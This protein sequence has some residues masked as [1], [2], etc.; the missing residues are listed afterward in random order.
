MSATVP[1]ADGSRDEDLPLKTAVLAKDLE[2]AVAPIA[3]ID[4]A[5]AI[6]SE[7]VH[8]IAK[9]PWSRSGGIGLRGRGGI[10]RL[11]AICAPVPF[12][13]ARLGVEH[14]HPVVLVH[15]T[16]RDIDLVAAQIHA[17]LRRLAH[18]CRDVLP[19]LFPGRPICDRNF[20]A[21]ENASM[22]VSLS[23]LPLIQTRSFAS[24]VMPCT[25]CGHS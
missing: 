16:V 20:P 22:C 2:S 9:L 12:V 4:E 3:H 8:G 21:R 24:T 14:N 10:I 19:P 23:P 13:G 17:H 7:A 5:V 25:C 6:D 18:V 1:P 15:F 11:L